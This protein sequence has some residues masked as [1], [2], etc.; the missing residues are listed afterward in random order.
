MPGGRDRSDIHEAARR[1]HVA[2]QL[3]RALGV[4]TVAEVGGVSVETARKWAL[5]GKCPAGKIER[6]RRA[7]K[8]ARARARTAE[9]KWQADE[10]AE[11]SEEE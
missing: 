4:S 9:S 8:R 5:T 10:L 7:L 3:A 11:A 2:F 1:K 6:L